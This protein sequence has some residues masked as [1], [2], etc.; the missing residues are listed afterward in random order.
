MIVHA[1][2]SERG[3]TPVALRVALTTPMRR[4]THIIVDLQNGFMAAGA[5]VKVPVAREIVPNVNQISAAVRVQGGVNIFLRMTV[6]SG[7]RE[8][9]RTGLRICTARKAARA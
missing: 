7:S 6:A 3:F 9:G 5:P 8:S 2:G 1:G 4:T